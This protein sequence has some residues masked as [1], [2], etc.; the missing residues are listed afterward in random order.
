MK[1]EIIFYA[2]LPVVAPYIGSLAL[3]RI[4]NIS[5]SLFI[6]PT[7][8]LVRLFYSSVSFTVKNGTQ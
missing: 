1:E 2:D 3:L 4:I 5:L 6:G 7:V 8:M